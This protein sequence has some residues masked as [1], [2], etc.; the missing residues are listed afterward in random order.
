[1]GHPL[2]RTISLNTVLTRLNTVLTRNMRSVRS[3]S[4]DGSWARDRTGW[5]GLKVGIGTS[6]TIFRVP[7][8]PYLSIF[9]I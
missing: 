4:W 7:S 9:R 8:A 5:V 2:Y 3:R 1:M 6:I